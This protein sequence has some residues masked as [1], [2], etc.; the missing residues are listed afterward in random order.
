MKNEQSTLIN[1]SWVL[2]GKMHTI[3]RMVLF[4]LCLLVL[5]STQS[6]LADITN[7]HF[8]EDLSSGWSWTP[9]ENVFYDSDNHWAV[10]RVD[11]EEDGSVTTLSQDVISLQ[12]SDKWLL[13]FD[14]VM[15][16]SEPGSET[17]EFTASFGTYR[18]TWK[19][20]VIFGS[21]PEMVSVVLD[22]AEWDPGPYE[23]VFELTNETDGI[24]TSVTI[25]NVQLSPVPVPGAVVLGSLGVGFAG[26]M[27]RRRAR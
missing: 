2:A 22:V 23:L 25:D 5:G 4:A 9:I 6:L 1:E 18:D 17:D 16:T 21:Y 8:S 14:F 3:K 15:A 27:L 10:L 26:W 24:L 19:A 13:S 7:G 12:T 11:D 20:P